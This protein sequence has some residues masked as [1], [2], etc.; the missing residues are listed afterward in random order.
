MKS[1]MSTYH[2][3]LVFIPNG[4]W[5]VICFWAFAIE[6]QK[7]T[8]LHYKAGGLFDQEFILGRTDYQVSGLGLSFIYDT[9]NN[10]FAP[11][12]G[13]MIQFFFNHFDP[14]FASGY[15]YTHFVLD[16]RKFLPF[17][18]QQ[19]LALQAFGDFNAGELALPVSPPRAVPGPCGGI[20]AAVPRL[21]PGGYP[22]QISYVSLLEAWRGGLY[23]CRQ[24]RQKAG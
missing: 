8:D 9:R 23:G 12:H 20:S 7:L 22:G 3:R 18:S 1:P 2:S 15:K 14:I 6:Y 24:C 4:L 19:G 17:S 16:L 13:S 11:N 5:A 21:K 10:A